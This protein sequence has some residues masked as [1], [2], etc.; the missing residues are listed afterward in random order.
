MRRRAGWIS[1]AILMALA[2][3]APG[4]P[5]DA[6]HVATPLTIQVVLTRGEGD[7]KVSSPY[8]LTAI[9]GQVASLRVGAE[10]PIGTTGGFTFQQIGTQIDSM[11]VAADGRYNVQITVTKREL[12]DVNS[13]PPIPQGDT[14]KPIFYNFV[15][16]GTVLLR[17]GETAQIIG[18]DMINNVTWR[19][20]ITLSLKK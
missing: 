16:A 3:T 6:S 13:A 17:N 10:V 5:Q 8:S 4:Y 12:Y 2:V 14:S 7:K 11:V 19:A 9:S 15:F 20:D 18:T 1:G